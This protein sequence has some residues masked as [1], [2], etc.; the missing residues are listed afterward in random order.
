SP[1]TSLDFTRRGAGDRWSWCDSL[2]MAP[3]VWTRLWKATGDR[4]YLDYAVTNWWITSEYLYDTHEHL[5]YRD[6]T[7]FERLESNGKRVFWGRG[8][9]WVLAGLARVI[10]DLPQ[11]HP[12]RGKF[13]QQFREMSEK[14]LECQQPDGLWR[15]SLLDPDSY[16]LKETSGSG[17]YA[18]GL[19]WGVNNGLLDRKRFA[20]AVNQAWVA[21]VDCVTPE[22]KLTH[23]QPIGADPKKFDLNH[24]DAYGVGAFLL[25]GSEI[26]RMNGGKLPPPKTVKPSKSRPA[27]AQDFQKV[28]ERYRDVALRGDPDWSSEKSATTSSAKLREWMTSLSAEGSWADVDYQ[29]QDRAF[30]KCVVH[31]DRTRLLAKAWT[32]PN[33]SLHHNA[34]LESATLRALDFWLA[35]RFQN[36]NWWWNQ[37]GVPGY[38]ADILALLNEKLTGER[39]TAAL[40]ILAQSGNPRSGSG[41]NTIW[42]ADLALQRGALMSDAKLIAECSRILAGEIKITTED[43]IQ[44]DY[45]FHQ[46]YARLQQFSYGRP[47]LSTA[48]RIAWQL[49]GTWSVPDDKVE[50]LAD[51]ALRGDQWMCRGIYTVPSTIDRSVSRP[52]TLAWSD[53]RTTLKQLVELLPGRANELKQFIARQNGNG[54]PLTGAR[55]FPRSDFATFHRPEFSFFLKTVSDRTLLSEVGLNDENLKGGLQNCG[56]H[57][58]LRDGREY[59]DLAPVWDWKLLPGVTFGEGAGELQRQAFVGSVTDGRDI[60]SAMD[61]RFGTKNETRLDAK[62]FWA[63]HGDVVICLIADLNAPELQQ[64]VR[65]ALDQCR[66][67]GA[68]TICDET[69]NQFSFSGGETNVN[70]RWVHHAGFGYAPLGGLSINVR[71]E[72]SSGSWQA[73]NRAL[74]SE[75]VTAPVFLPVLEHGIA[76][77]HQNGGFVI[78]A[79]NVSNVAT[80]FKKPSWRVLRNDS[81]VQAVKFEDGTML[82]AFYGAGESAGQGR[83]ELTADQPC[84]VLARK[85]RIWACDPTQ[86]GGRVTIRWNG[87]SQ[88]ADLLPNGMTIELP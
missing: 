33:S 80:V 55:N 88:V 38:M 71:A 85:K 52:G 8:N 58:L 4:R 68:V 49:Q 64:P 72:S 62:K 63:A 11:D 3:P 28:V 23:V 56:D 20:P 12:S 82:A 16:P 51:L 61:Y 54:E 86:R 19:A 5:F 65:T 30:W 81:D 77:V 27:T 59:L 15:S 13:V 73:I 75:T 45:S 6:S 83:F 69:G 21:L 29:D 87:K 10:Q 9:G 41:A 40:E 17:F 43:G 25:A 34:D 60:A 78:A 14:I 22:G 53:I 76:P 32:D 42:I 57:Y 46:H 2:F 7:Y 74:S 67:R 79:G 26:Y 31:L 44:P 70:A 36:P 24:T 39:R 84:I 18:Y 37:I 66:W 47:Y 35:K 50:I 1:V 48:A